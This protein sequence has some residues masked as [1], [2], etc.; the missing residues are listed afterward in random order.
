M[1]WRNQMPVWD[2]DNHLKQTQAPVGVK[3]CPKRQ[4]DVDKSTENWEKTEVVLMPFVS[5]HH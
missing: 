5:P 1:S 3:F 4:F 2:R